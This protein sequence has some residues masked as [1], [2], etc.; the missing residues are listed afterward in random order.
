MKSEKAPHGPALA[1]AVASAYE[2]LLEARTLAE[3]LAALLAGIWA[4]DKRSGK[5]PANGPTIGDVQEALVTDRAA[6]Q[7]FLA[8][9]E[10]VRPVAPGGSYSFAVELGLAGGD[11]LYLLDGGS[12]VS[13]LAGG[14]L[15]VIERA[16][17]GVIPTRL[18]LPDV[19]DAWR[20]A[21]LA[22]DAAAD[23]RHPFAPLVRAWIDR[24][25]VIRCVAATDSPH[26][27]RRCPAA[28]IVTAAG[29]GR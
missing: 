7:K 23:V 27:E 25:P 6:R 14:A 18:S 28:G 5:P 22:A 4:D 9:L 17:G 3:Q 16:G 1:M 24:R 21:A 10:A 12:H 29:L 19:A 13:E 26:D 15:H 11:V 2:A 8:R 20:G